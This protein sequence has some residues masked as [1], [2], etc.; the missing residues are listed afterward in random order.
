MS[1]GTGNAFPVFDSPVGPEHLERS[2][3]RQGGKS[4]AFNSVAQALKSLIMKART[5]GTEAAS[6]WAQL[7][8]SEIELS[9]QLV[10]IYLA[11]AQPPAS[12]REAW[13]AM[14][15]RGVPW[16][17]RYTKHARIVFNGEAPD[18]AGAGNAGLDDMGMDM[19]LVGNVGMIREADVVTV[20]VLRDGQFLPGLAVELRHLGNGRAVSTGAWHRTDDQ[21]RVR[22]SV[23]L[24]GRW[25]LRGIDIRKS[26]SAP[27]SWDTRFA[28]LAFD[29]AAAR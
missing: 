4:V 11:E 13:L 18:D 5:R 21:G 22:L 2:G 1:L 23:P 7:V 14:A 17:E 24:A 25:L 12:V 15:A 8:S 20:Q 26:V 27:D 28:T 9:T 16:R 6:C 10:P 29:V 19:V 3:C